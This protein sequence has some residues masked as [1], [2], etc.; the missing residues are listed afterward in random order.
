MAWKWIQRLCG[1]TSVKK[2]RRPQRF[3][4]Q[5]L[6]LEDRAVPAVI[7]Q[8][9]F[10]GIRAGDV[11][12]GAV[13]PDTALAVGPGQVIEM[14]NAAARIST[15]DG[16]TLDHIDMTVMFPPQTPFALTFDP[17]VVYDDVAQRFYVAIL[18][19]DTLALTSFL[20]IAISNTST[21]ASFTTDFTER[22]TIDL[23]QTSN[24]NGLLWGD[25]PK[26]GYNYDGLF[27]TTNMFSFVGNIYDHTQIVSFLKP[28]ILDQNN[29]TLR[30]NQTNRNDLN[31]TMV[32]ALM[33]DAKPFEPMYFIGASGDSDT[34]LR[35]TKMTNHFAPNPGFVVHDIAVPHYN[36]GNTPPAIQPDDFIPPLSTLT[37]NDTR[38]Q[39]A[40]TRR[41]RLVTT[42]AI[43]KSGEA[44]VRWYEIDI[45]PALG[46]PTLIQNGDIDPGPSVYTFFPAIDIAANLDIGITYMQVSPFE[47]LSMYVTG[48]KQTDPKTLMQPPVLVRGGDAFYAV[49]VA[50]RLGDYAGIGVDPLNPNVFWAANEYASAHIAADNWATWIS[51]F[52]VSPLIP[53]PVKLINPLRWNID[54]ATGNLV[55]NLIVSNTSPTI[56][57]NLTLHIN[58]PDASVTLVTP[59]GTRTGNRYTVPM[60]GPFVQNVPRVVPIVISNPLRRPLGTALI[61]IGFS[62][63]DR[64]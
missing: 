8:R 39:A 59:V 31:F 10:E 41:N 28:T 19:V 37:T 36:N 54:R 7:V 43:D 38:I 62:L 33:H 21:P 50:N 3:L 23:V 45:N 64:F 16:A 44:T 27:V 2:A 29:A 32:P 51:A 35:I 6:A 15:K 57:G 42:H 30:F 22:I 4:P 46:V 49:G 14:V 53:S 34:A 61:G 17:V 58:V 26:M 9:G 20:H 5:M 13:P 11:G 40:A 1:A 24:I 47:F 56:T 52:N 25:Y 48:R 55:G 12:T 60:T 18:E 63:G